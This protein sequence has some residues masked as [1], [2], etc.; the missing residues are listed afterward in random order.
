MHRWVNGWLSPGV[1]NKSAGVNLRALA[2]FQHKGTG[3]HK[4]LQRTW[5]QSHSEEAAGG[6]AW[7]RRM[8]FLQETRSPDPGLPK[9][10]GTQ[11]GVCH[12]LR[13]KQSFPSDKWKPENNW[14]KFSKQKN[15][16]DLSSSFC[17]RW[18]RTQ[19]SWGQVWSHFRVSSTFTGVRPVLP[20]NTRLQVSMIS[21]H[22]L[23]TTPWTNQQVTRG[24]APKAELHH[25]PARG[26]WANYL[27]LTVSVSSAAKQKQ[28]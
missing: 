3:T 22:L 25:V 16:W 24:G 2:V 12:F 14:W 28:Y 9:H 26:T 19:D 23:H 13:T 7:S 27:T 21:R 4:W 11:M 17:P 6:K 20:N 1:L 5:A 10:L 8:M 15:R 18:Q